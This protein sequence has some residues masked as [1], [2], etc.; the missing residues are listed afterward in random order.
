M[1][2]PTQEMIVKQG[3]SRNPEGSFSP[4]PL[5]DMEPYLDREEFK[6]N[7]LVKPWSKDS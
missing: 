1:V 2:S 4:R 6:K 5:E 7:M 3:F